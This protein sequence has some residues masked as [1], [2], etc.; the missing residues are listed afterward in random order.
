M[1]GSMDATEV[2]LAEVHFCGSRQ[3]SKQVT[4]SKSRLLFLY[5]KHSLNNDQRTIR[6]GYL[7]AQYILYQ[8]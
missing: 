4:I 8:Q 7:F 3:H 6:L 2:V 5:L 1:K